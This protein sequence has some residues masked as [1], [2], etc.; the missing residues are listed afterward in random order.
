MDAKVIEGGL[1]S[2]LWE[3]FRSGN[4][5]IGGV[6]LCTSAKHA[7]TDRHQNALRPIAALVGSAVE[8]WLTRAQ[9]YSRL[10][11]YGR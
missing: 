7:F 9:L 6:W 4:T 5:C 1:G 10:E 2:G 11:K 8:R 3:P